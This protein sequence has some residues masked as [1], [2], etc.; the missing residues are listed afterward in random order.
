MRRHS[1]FRRHRSE[2]PRKPMV[3]R[4]G[5][6]PSEQRRDSR[7]SREELT[8]HR[9]CIIR[10]VRRH[11]TQTFHHPA[12]CTPQGA[13]PRC[14]Q[15]PRSRISNS[16]PILLLTRSPRPACQC[17]PASAGDASFACHGRRL[18]SQ[19]FHRLRRHRFHRPPHDRRHHLYCC[20]YRRRARPI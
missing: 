3:Q 5:V 10:Y 20:P 16:C 14:D 9:R 18:L 12:T 4:E 6:Q 17:H 11:V 1:Q 13:I 7:A 8:H 19:T 15:P 2:G